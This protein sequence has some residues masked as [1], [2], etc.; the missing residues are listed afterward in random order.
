[1]KRKVWFVC[2]WEEIYDPNVSLRTVRNWP[3]SDKLEISE[4]DYEF[5]IVLGGFRPQDMRYYRNPMKTIGFLLEPNWSTNW[6]RDL[7]KYCKYVIAQESSMFPGQNIIEHPL[8]MMTQST[9][10][11]K[12]YLEQEHPKSR[13]MSIVITNTGPK[14]LYNERIGLFKALLN[15][16]LDI[17]FY[18]RMWNINDSRYK[19]APYNKSDALLNYEYSIGIENCRQKNYLT[20]KF[21]D[22]IACDT[23][24]IYYGA[25]NVEEIY[26]KQSFI[27]MDFSGPIEKTVEQITDIYHNDDYSARLP[28]VK[29]AKELYYT[30][31][32]IFN[33]LESMIDRGM[34]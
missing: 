2:N 26:P 30:K 33:F 15:T 16:D 13:R 11:H 31:Y 8:F 3:I 1:M 6:Q 27:E 10:H 25:P 12:F 22:L 23:V 32:N 18:G 4:T 20:E 21:F 34:I 29:K 14:P 19:G 5:L 24:P 17:D 9:D 28:N 7:D